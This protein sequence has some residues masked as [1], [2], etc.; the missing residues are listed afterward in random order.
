MI[1]YSGGESPNGAMGSQVLQLNIKTLK[2]G[3]GDMPE[4]FEHHKACDRDIRRIHR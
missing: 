3:A 1:C 4:R 2:K